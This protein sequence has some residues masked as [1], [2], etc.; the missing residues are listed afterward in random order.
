MLWM[1]RIIMKISIIN[2]KN[3]RKNQHYSVKRKQVLLWF[4]VAIEKFS[5]WKNKFKLCYLI[6]CTPETHPCEYENR[7]HDMLFFVTFISFPFLFS[8]L[9]FFLFCY[10]I[11]VRTLTKSMFFQPTSWWIQRQRVKSNKMHVKISCECLFRK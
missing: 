10:F 6:I 9:F 11:I 8:I 4:S 1:K 2:M 7:W 5:W 3:A